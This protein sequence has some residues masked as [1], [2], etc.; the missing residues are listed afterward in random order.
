[1]RDLESQ[2]EQLKTA[3]QEEKKVT[4]ETSQKKQELEVE[5][6]SVNQRAQSERLAFEQLHKQFQ[7]QEEEKKK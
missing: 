4:E 6:V 3:L 5:V 2:L 1:M 7:V